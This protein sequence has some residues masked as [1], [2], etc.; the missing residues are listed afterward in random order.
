MARPVVGVTIHDDTLRGLEL[1]GGKP[2]AWGEVPL[3]EGT[4]EQGVVIDTVAF[5]DALKALWTSAGFK[6]KRIAIAVETEAATI[7]R[8]SLPGA[9]AD[10]IA[11]A[12]A[13]DIAEILSYPADEAV[14]DHAVLN[15]AAIAERRSDQN[16][17]SEF[18][19][20]AVE[21][22]VVA[23]R[24]ETIEAFTDAAKAA[25]LKWIRAELAPA[26]NVSLVPAENEAATTDTSSDTQ[27]DSADHTAGDTAN[28][29]AGDTANDTADDG[30]GD[31]AADAGLSF[32]EGKR[33]SLGAIVSIGERTTTVSVHDG[34]GLLFARVLMTGVGE[35]A[36][37]SHE[38]ES[39]LAE[40]ESL[41]AGGH[42]STDA[43]VPNNDAPGAGVVAEGIRRTLHFHMTDIDKRS[44]D[45]VILCGSRSRASGLLDRVREAL[46]AASVSVLE[47]DDWPEFDEPERFDT[48]F[49]VARLVLTSHSDHLRDLSLVPISVVERARDGR[50]VM[51][52]VAAAAVLGV[53]AFGSLQTRSVANEQRER[54]VEAAEAAVDQARDEVDRFDDQQSLVTEIERRRGMVSTLAADRVG[55]SALI[56]RIAEAMPADSVIRSLQITTGDATES[57]GPIIVA[58]G[59]ASDLDGVAA[60]IEG[61]NA[62]GLFSDMTLVSTAVGQFGLEERNVAV[63]QVEGT[64]S[65]NAFAA[66]PEILT[67]E[68]S[69]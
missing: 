63:F 19:D 9:V 50:A 49:A 59:A 46:P 21:T 32:A 68:Q 33:R 4:I 45:H 20:P 22:L 10:D 16:D 7:R 62:S 61:V 66:L 43:Y 28:D 65:G 24:R 13:Y 53:A 2:R 44:I 6:T 47:H 34:G 17:F 69:E 41:R 29:T 42:A 31:A 64:V 40:V 30:A 48:A 1:S 26:A 36:S 27:L 51:V 54:T 67:K 15:A 57:D 11:E 25:G 8:V 23:V 37:L 60:W 39:Q 14:I 52:G 55:I 58:E 18:D 3:P 12:A 5:S 56:G 38:L 35:T